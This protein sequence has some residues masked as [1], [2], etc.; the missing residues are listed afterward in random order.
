MSAR[1]VTIDRE[2]PLLFPEDLG[3]WVPEN[4]IVHFII[5][6]A[7]RLDIGSFKVNEGGSEQYPPEMMPVLLM[8]CYVSK[9]MP[10]RVIEEATYSDVAVR[11]LCGNRAHPD[12]TVICRFRGENREAFTKVLVRRRRRR[13][14]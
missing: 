1:F 4:H 10:S 12:H 11:Y 7:G 9:R 13:G 3:K 14:C 5:E 8:Y 2:T 6:A